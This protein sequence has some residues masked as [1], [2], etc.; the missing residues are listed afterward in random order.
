MTY[1][2][3]IIRPEM[4]EEQVIPRGRALSADER[5]AVRKALRTLHALEIMAV[6]IYKCQI[7]EDVTPLNTALTTAMSN[8]MTH[9]QD[10]QTHLYE[11]G[12]TPDKL[13]ARFWLAGY[14]FG[15]GSRMMGTKR[16][17]KTGIWAEN[18]AVDHYGKL[19]AS[20]PWDDETRA[21]IE[22]D[23]AD[24]YGHIARWE[25]FLKG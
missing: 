15:L 12:I 4:H 3:T 6:N 14:V 1:D 9:M 18:K 22:K 23:R 20:A 25:G 24:E 8:E 10:F 11:Y 17:L 2:I 5:R 16:V 13:R 7:T 19:L 21:V